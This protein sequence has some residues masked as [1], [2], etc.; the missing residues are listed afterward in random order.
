MGELFEVFHPKNRKCVLIL[1]L[2]IMS[3]EVPPDT[4]L[5]M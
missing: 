5:V 1:M 3:Y 2:E 4:V